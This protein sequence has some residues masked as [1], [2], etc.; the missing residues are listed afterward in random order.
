MSRFQAERLLLR[1][2]DEGAFLVRSSSEPGSLS[3]S[4]RYVGRPVLPLD[5]QLLATQYKTSLVSIF[6]FGLTF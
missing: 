6:V 4:F 5:S 3:L 1:I 2:P